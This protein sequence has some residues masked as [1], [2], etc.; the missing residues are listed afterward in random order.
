VAVKIE[1]EKTVVLGA[2]KLIGKLRPKPA[3]AAANKPS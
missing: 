2:V 3:A 1:E